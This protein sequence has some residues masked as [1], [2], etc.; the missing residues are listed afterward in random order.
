MA[1]HTRRIRIICVVAAMVAVLVVML[2]FARSRLWDTSSADAAPDEIAYESFTVEALK[3]Y[4]EH[5]QFGP[6][7]GNVVIR[8]L[9]ADS[10]AESGN[11]PLMN[12]VNRSD[13]YVVG[14]MCRQDD[15]SAFT[16]ALS[17]ADGGMYKLISSGACT[18]DGVA[19]LSLPIDR[20]PHASS[21]SVTV[22]QGTTMVFAIYEIKEIR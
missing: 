15:P 9:G 13:E 18:S 10:L 19:M 4:M 12:A 11:V 1:W 7:K 22:S 6:D 20:F 3:T 2:S 8:V 16:I 14:Y 21:V 17:D 5:E